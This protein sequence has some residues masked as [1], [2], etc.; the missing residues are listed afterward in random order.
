MSNCVSASR[1]L[2]RVLLCFH[3]DVLSLPAGKPEHVT[4]ARDCMLDMAT[5]HVQQVRQRK[6][7][8]QEVD[9]EVLFFYQDDEVSRS[10]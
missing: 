10:R 8:Q 4:L 1:V 2:G 9:D 5:S 3:R 6:K 7:Q